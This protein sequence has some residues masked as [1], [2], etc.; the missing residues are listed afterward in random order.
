MSEHESDQTL[1]N[2]EEFHKM[3]LKGRKGLA[4]NSSIQSFMKDMDLS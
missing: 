1:L 2:E 3:E 4:N